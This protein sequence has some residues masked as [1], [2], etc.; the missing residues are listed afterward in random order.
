MIKFI[1]KKVEQ[2]EIISEISAEEAKAELIISLNEEAKSEASGLKQ[3][4]IEEAKLSAEQ[5]A[6]KIIINT[7]QTNRD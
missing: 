7:I 2:L 4:L 1:F 5:E 3:S 6:K